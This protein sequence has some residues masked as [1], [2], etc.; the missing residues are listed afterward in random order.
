M[1][2]VKKK[3]FTTLI[4]VLVG[5]LTWYLFIKED[6]YIFTFRVKTSPGTVYYLAK[7]WNTLKGKDPGLINNIDYNPYKNLKQEFIENNDHYIFN[8]QFSAIDE[9]TTAVKVGIS[10]SKGSFLDR[11]SLI[12]KEIPLISVGKEKLLAF[13]TIVKNHL[14]DFK[15][16]VQDQGI[17]PGG[18][19]AYMT[20]ESSMQNKAEKMI[21]ENAAIT[22]FLAQN[23]FIVNGPPVV[24]ILQWDR[25]NDHI[26]FN[27]CFPV[28]K[29]DSLPQHQAIKFKEIEAFKGLKAIFNGNYRISDRAWFALDTYAAKKKYEIVKE[30]VEV[31]YNNP[32]EG[33]NAL[34]WKAE[35]FMPLK[36]P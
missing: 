2:R 14:N 8:W 5:S 12:F 9:E 11:L 17:F 24:E 7:R 36:N 27:F 6:D 20:I 3:V 28:E 21:A 15:V 33:G 23:K 10:D 19:F 34:E 32:N 1:K 25:K 13:N 31:F 16:N 35:I 22:S 18:F 29:R 4:L 30:P 26:K